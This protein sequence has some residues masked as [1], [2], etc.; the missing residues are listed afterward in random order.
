MIDA[1]AQVYLMEKLREFESRAKERRRHET[2]TKEQTT[3]TRTAE[4]RSSPARRGDS[5][6]RSHGS[7]RTAAGS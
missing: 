6:W 1:A 4:Q 5:G 2:A 3:S 7:W